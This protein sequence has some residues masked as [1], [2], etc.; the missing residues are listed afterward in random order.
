LAGVEAYFEAARVEL[1]AEG[2]VD[3]GP[4]LAVAD[5][6]FEGVEAAVV[7]KLKEWR[8]LFYGSFCVIS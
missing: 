2:A 8:Y 4:E 3:C 1:A 7:I 6:M 5:E